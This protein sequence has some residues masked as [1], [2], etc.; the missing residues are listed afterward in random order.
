MFRWYVWSHNGP[1][2]VTRMLQNWCQVYYISWMTPERC[3][4]FRILPPKSFYPVHY[5]GAHVWNSLSSEWVVNKNSNQ[6]YAQM[7]RLSCPR[8][9]N[10]A[11]QQF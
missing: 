6:Y 3:K 7:A 5:V 9:F 2:L 4:G 8:I 1:D 10:V 11:P